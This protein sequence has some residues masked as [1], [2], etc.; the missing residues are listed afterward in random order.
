MGRIITSVTVE[1]FASP[2]F[3][4]RCDALVDTGASHLVLPSAWRERLGELQLLEKV[5]VEVADQSILRGE[6]RGPVKVQI[7]G[8]RAVSS[9]VLFLDM[10]PKDDRYEP[11][12]GYIVLEQS[13]A[14]VD[15]VGHQLIHVKYFD[16]K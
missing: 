13:L 16:A 7:E 11:L 10:K 15:M 14:A 1:N 2:Q 8:F 12:V 6:I 5:D 9:E 3:T 4:L